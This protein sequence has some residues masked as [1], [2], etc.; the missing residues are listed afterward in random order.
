M[1][2]AK[3]IDE[4]SFGMEPHHWPL[5]ERQEIG[6]MFELSGFIYPFVRFQDGSIYQIHVDMARYQFGEE[7]LVH[8]ID[9]RF[10][11]FLEFIE[12]TKI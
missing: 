7:L 1:T 2:I 8:W 3:K 4:T 5:I 11:D 9:T 10:S 6:V 12:L